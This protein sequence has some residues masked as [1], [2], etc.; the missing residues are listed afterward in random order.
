MGMYVKTR[1]RRMGREGLQA[2]MLLWCCEKRTG[3]RLGQDF[4]WMQCCCE[5]I[6]AQ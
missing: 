6:L 4:L 3:R 5:K 2:A 1:R